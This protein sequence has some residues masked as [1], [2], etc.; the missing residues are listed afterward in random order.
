MDGTTLVLN[1]SWEPLRVV[2]LTRAV[3]LVFAQRAEV[4]EEAERILHSAR[5]SMR[6][7]AVIRLV[8]M[9]KVPFRSRVP[10]TRAHLIARDKG[11]CGYCGVHVGNRGTID[12]IVP[13]SKGGKHDWTNVVTACSPCNSKK[14]DKT[15][16]QL[17]WTLRTTPYTPKGSTW[18]IVGLSGVNESWAPY[19][20][21]LA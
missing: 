3:S 11:L 7:P 2:P 4:V 8:R 5:T 20:P 13:R 19:L 14:D 16:A 21:A 15:L 6:A 9:V 18:V 12:H 17:G 10:L 1:A